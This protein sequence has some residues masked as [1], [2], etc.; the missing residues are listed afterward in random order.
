MEEVTRNRERESIVSK[1]PQG[2]SPGA[3]TM[4]LQT[5]RY[6]WF[7]LSLALGAILGLVLLV[8]ALLSYNF[9]SGRL[10]VEQAEREATRQVVFLE[11][12]A[13]QMSIR[14]PADLQ[15]M[16]DE[17]RRDENRKIA[18]IRL[19]DPQGATLVHSGEVT[20]SSFPAES[21]RALI[22]EREPLSEVRETPE[23]SVLVTVLPFRV[24]LGR[25]VTN[26]G[27]MKGPARRRPEPSGQTP[28]ARLRLAEIALYPDAVSGAFGPLRRNLIISCSAALALVASMII[29]GLRLGPYVRGRQLEQQLALARKVQQEL[30]PVKGSSIEILDFAGECVPAEAV[31]GDFY[32]IFPVEQQRV[33]LLLGDVSG[34]GLSAAL[35]MGLVLGAL[36]SSSWFATPEEHEASFRRLN[37]LLCTRTSGE[38]FTTLFSCYY[39]IG[40]GILHY[41][42]AGHLP[43]ILVASNGT[44]NKIYRLPDGG[45]VLGLLPGADYSQG[46]APFRPGDL[47]LLYSDGIV[48][49]ANSAGEEFGE[50]RLC[51][52]TVKNRV[53]SAHQIRNEI[54]TQVRSYLSRRPPHDDLT[55]LV[56]RASEESGRMSWP[57][58]AQE[59]SQ[60]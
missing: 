6:L 47:L 34:K 37:E 33:A 7:K 52:I 27:Q 40:A 21:L 55:L 56:V 48:E 53:Q 17:L 20:G 4:S 42:N 24:P 12:H 8:Q 60:P 30:L 32:D 1:K 14:D 51:A 5:P 54:L 41:V 2:T 13:R 15:S 3:G 10:V 58:G 26:S 23:G 46:S 59:H 43:P 19:I 16:L 9:V 31:G 22:Q 25:P 28:G 44:E 35:L 36:R 11:R 57:R 18:W 29:M 49:A 50:E 39:D 38:R 45:P